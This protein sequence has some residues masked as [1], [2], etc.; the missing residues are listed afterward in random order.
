MN[1]V[2][3]RNNG[4]K[5]L[6]D[7]V[8]S[9]SKF[10][11]KNF[12][13]HRVTTRQI[14]QSRASI[15]EHI[16]R[17]ALRLL[18]GTKSITY[19]YKCCTANM[20]GSFWPLTHMRNGTIYYTKLVGINHWNHRLMGLPFDVLWIVLYKRLV[21]KDISSSHLHLRAEMKT[22]KHDQQ[23]PI[24]N[25]APSSKSRPL[26]ARSPLSEIIACVR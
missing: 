14:W 24:P 17:C 8:S 10:L 26:A 5:T 7:H 19:N 21:Y 2:A 15:S 22:G 4:W 13:Y 3:K 23:P 1:D 20:S 18:Q 12:C 16:A 25:K 6:S 9:Q 11:A